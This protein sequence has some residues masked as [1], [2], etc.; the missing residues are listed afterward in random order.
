[1]PPKLED[2]IIYTPRFI[3]KGQE[4]CTPLI[5]RQPGVGRSKGPSLA[6]F[7]EF[8]F[9][10]LL[11]AL[12][13]Q[14]FSWEC[15]SLQ[16]PSTCTTTLIMIFQD[17][18]QFI[19]VSFFSAL[20]ATYAYSSI[21]RNFHLIHVLEIYLNFTESWLSLPLLRRGTIVTFSLLAGAV[22]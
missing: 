19:R 5:K 6:F 20:S 4:Y 14:A 1:M 9:V 21:K 15:E 17:T 18:Y 11:V 16:S 8:E 2:P 22:Q 10:F 12:R 13:I 3:H 7:Q